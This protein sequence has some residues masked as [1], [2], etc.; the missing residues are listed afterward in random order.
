MQVWEVKDCESCVCIMQS[1]NLSL[2]KRN[3]LE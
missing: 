1:S 3:G 2:Q